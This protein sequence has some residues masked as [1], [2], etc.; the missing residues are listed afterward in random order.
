MSPR[1][2]GSAGIF[3]QTACFL[4]GVPART[5]VCL[6]L[7][8]SGRESPRCP[9]A[10]GGLPEEPV[11]FS[12]VS[13]AAP[14]GRGFAS[15][16]SHHQP[17]HRG[18]PAYAGG[19][20][21]FPFLLPPAGHCQEQKEPPQRS[22]FGQDYDTEEPENRVAGTS[23][24]LKSND[25]VHQLESN[26]PLQE[27]PSAKAN[28]TRRHRQAYDQ[29]RRETPERRECRRRYAQEQRQRAKEL[30]QVPRLQQ[31][32]YPGTDQVPQVC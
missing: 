30:R 6:Q 3:H 12:R 23:G 19:R 8:D 32:R 18:R 7:P 28:D 21:N 29:T 16:H 4:H 13:W 22:R 20:T 2:R 27:I 31:A 14:R 17:S 1:G 25:R 15:A 24:L 9:R 5:G 26:G 11:T 10:D